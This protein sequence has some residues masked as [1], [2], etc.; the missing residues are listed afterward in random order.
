MKNETAGNPL[1]SVIIP[2]FNQAQFLPDA[3]DSLLAQTYPEWDCHIVDDGSTDNTAA[4]AQQYT[5]KD[6]RF[7][8]IFQQ[9]KGLSGA[10]NTGLRNARGELI[11]FLDADDILEPEKIELQ[12]KAMQKTHSA[13]SFTDYYL[14]DTTRSRRYWFRMSPKISTNSPLRDLI[15]SWNVGLNIP[16]HAFLFE[17][18]LFNEGQCSFHENLFSLEDWH[19]WVQVFMLKPAFCFINRKLVGYRIRKG[20]MA[21]DPDKACREFT[22]A[23]RFLIEALPPDSQAIHLLQQRLPLIRK[24]YGKMGKFYR[25]PRIGLRILCDYFR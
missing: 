10:R 20:S 15:Q 5:H 23:V 12:V 21:R 18:K 9:N 3:L 16:N 4:I 6:P 22:K 13:V 17:T 25:F 2:A 14:T 11:Q 1:V 8:Y 19:C 24:A 7:H